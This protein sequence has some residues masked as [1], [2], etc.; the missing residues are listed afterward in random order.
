MLVA[1]SPNLM[2][3]LDHQ[4]PRTPE[5]DQIALRSWAMALRLLRNSACDFWTVL[6][7]IRRGIKA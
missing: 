4:M 5:N 6:S 3:F 1:N 7:L 2:L